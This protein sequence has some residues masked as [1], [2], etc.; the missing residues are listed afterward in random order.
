MNKNTKLAI[1]ATVVIG[2]LIGVFLFFLFP[3]KFNTSKTA[4]GVQKGE[5]SEKSEIAVTLHIKPSDIKATSPSI[6]FKTQIDK[7][8]KAVFTV[9]YTNNSN[10]DLT[11]VQ[12]W[13]SVSDGKDYGFLTSQNAKFVKRLPMNAEIYTEDSI[14]QVNDVKK[15]KKAVADIIFYSRVP[16]K[17]GITA[18]LISSQGK[19]GTSNS[20]ILVIK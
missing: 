4:V 6:D 15:G 8:N 19:I 9:T 7:I 3:Q 18:K 17:I 2:V 13:I 12:V 10:Q 5:G 11:G 14:F 20:G 16:D 1:V